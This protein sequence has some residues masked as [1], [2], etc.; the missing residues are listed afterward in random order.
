MKRSVTFHCQEC[1]RKV[2]ARGTS[3]KKCRHCDKCAREYF[4]V[5]K[6][7]ESV[8]RSAINNGRLPRARSMSCVDC[9]APA[10]GYDHRDYL[11]PLDVVPTCRSCNSRRGGA[12]WKESQPVENFLPKKPVRAFSPWVSSEGDAGALL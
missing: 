9:G 4:L 3:P 2:V 6:V 12:R 7:A 5:K 11:K 10:N 8:F 1:K